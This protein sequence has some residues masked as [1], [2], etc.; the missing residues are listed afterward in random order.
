MRELFFEPGAFNAARLGLRG[1]V[2]KIVIPPGEGLLHVVGNL[3][4]MLAAASGRN[5]KTSR[6]RL[7]GNAQD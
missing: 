7:Y 4:E 2:E 6:C 1:F 5:G 3:G